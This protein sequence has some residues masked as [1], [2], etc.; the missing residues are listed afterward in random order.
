MTDLVFRRMKSRPES[1]DLMDDV[2]QRSCGESRTEYKYVAGGYTAMA[3]KSLVDASLASWE[4]GS[5]PKPKVCPTCGR[6]ME[7]E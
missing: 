3:A 2:S 4:Y 7:R 1:Y 5:E 6:K